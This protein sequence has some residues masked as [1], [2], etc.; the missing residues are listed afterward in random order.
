M[1]RKECP[2]KV[3]AGVYLERQN[4][5]AQAAQLYASIATAQTVM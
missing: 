2:G 5:C 3:A 4:I 1:N